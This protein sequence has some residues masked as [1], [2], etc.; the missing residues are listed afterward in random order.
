MLKVSVL[1]ITASLLLFAPTQRL[2][3]D[4]PGLRRATVVQATPAPAPVRIPA[5]PARSGFQDQQTEADCVVT[6]FANAARID[7]ATL[8][9]AVSAY[10]E[11]W[12]TPDWPLTPAEAS[13]GLGALGY[14]VETTQATPDALRRAPYGSVVV[15][16]SHAWNLVSYN[17]SS[18]VL[19]VYDLA[20]SKQSFNVAVL[21]VTRYIVTGYTI[22]DP[23]AEGYASEIAY[24]ALYIVR[25]Q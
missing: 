8:V 4:D 9:N 24:P 19:R 23:G 14:S 6:A 16:K 12:W 17:A 21:A 15:F 3:D 13:L 25:P 11:A 5:A 20:G 2:P 10:H 18:G 1:F 22:G 7:R